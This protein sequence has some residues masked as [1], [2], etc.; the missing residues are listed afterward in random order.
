MDFACEHGNALI[1]HAVKNRLKNK[2]TEVKVAFL[3]CTNTW[4]ETPY[5]D[6][7]WQI[8]RF[9]RKVRKDLEKEGVTQ[10]S[11]EQYLESETFAEELAKELQLK[12]DDILRMRGK[13]KECKFAQ[14]LVTVAL[15]IDQTGFPIDCHVYAENLSELKTLKP[16]LESLKKKYAV[17]D[18][19]FVADRGLNSTENLKLGFVV[20]QKVSKQKEDLRKPMLDLAGYSSCGIDKDGKFYRK[21][22]EANP[23]AFRFKVIDYVKKSRVEVEDPEE[24]KGAKTKQISV[25][26]RMVFTFSPGRKARDLADLENQITRASRAVQEQTLMGNPFGTGWRA[27]IQTEKEA[28]ETKDEKEQYRA[29]GLK[30]EVIEERRAIAGYAALV[31]SHPDG[32]KAQRLTDEEVLNTYHELV[33]IEDCF[34]VMKSTFSIRPVYVRLNERIKGHCYLCV[35]ALML[36]KS[37]QERMEAKGWH[38]STAKLSDGLAQAL[39]LL[40]PAGPDLCKHFFKSWHLSKAL[41]REGPL[42]ASSQCAR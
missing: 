41:C 42:P 21:E 1:E 16:M 2:K 36:I 40:L 3:D 11:I 24:N 13:S 22:G 7:V 23:D 28:A 15:A 38:Y 35:L 27:L 32:E 8:I 12:K 14:P 26:C 31:F 39:A 5:D 4:F 33:S 29:C 10:E 37:L 9:T 18:V 20:A 30:Q 34:R 25:P 17:K 6:L 19:Y